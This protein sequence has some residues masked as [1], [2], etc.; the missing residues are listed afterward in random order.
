LAVDEDGVF[1]IFGRAFV[2]SFL[3]VY[4][5][6]ALSLFCSFVFILSGDEVESEAESGV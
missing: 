5:L 4:Q 1:A 6:F 3:C 2:G